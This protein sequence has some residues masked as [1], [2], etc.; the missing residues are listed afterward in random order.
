MLTSRALGKD[1][2]FNYFS[3]ALAAL[4]FFLLFATMSIRS[5][6]NYGVGFFCTGSGHW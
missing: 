4:F 3:I 1:I 6:I 2:H 5:H